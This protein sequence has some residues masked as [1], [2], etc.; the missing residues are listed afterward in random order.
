MAKPI[1]M[2]SYYMLI[3]ILKEEMGVLG[4]DYRPTDQKQC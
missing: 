3:K 4:P 2:Y 1:I